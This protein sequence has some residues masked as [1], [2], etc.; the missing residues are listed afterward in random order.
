MIE[1][2]QEIQLYKK[3]QEELKQQLVTVNRS[4]EYQFIGGSDVS[5]IGDSGIGVVVVFD[6]RFNLVDRAVIKK[7]VDFP[8]IPGFLAFREVPLILEAYKS[9]KVKPDIVLVDGQGIAH[10]RGFG[11]ASHL[12]VLLNIPT[13]GV[14]K[15][16]LY[17]VCEA[18][19]P[20]RG[21]YTY[22][23][24]R[25]NRI[26][27]ACLVTKDNTKPLYV[28]IGHLVDLEMAIRVVLENTIHYRLPE[29][30]RIAHHYTQIEK[31][32]GVL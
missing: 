27:G 23:R 18:P 4:E 5:Y 6:R 32:G 24:D 29:P 14:A 10:P 12:G 25:N 8:Y 16:R 9:L 28:S 20:R 3:I 19:E 31:R 17:G 1:K 2:S 21:S 26:I 11:V 7:K 13:I 15:N 30:L 22:L